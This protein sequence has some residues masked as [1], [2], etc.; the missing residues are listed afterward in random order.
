MC[1]DKR[2][3]SVRMHSRSDPV[4]RIHRLLHRM[5]GWAERMDLTACNVIRSVEA[6][7]ATPS[8]LSLYSHVVAGPRNGLSIP[9]TKR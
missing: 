5:F 7:K 8:P 4:V 2:T 9:S 6:P 1:S 3:T